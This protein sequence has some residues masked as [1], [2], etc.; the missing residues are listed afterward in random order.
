MVWAPP[1]EP[2]AIPVTAMRHP[3]ALSTAVAIPNLDH[4]AAPT[5]AP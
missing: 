4:G 5:W 3:A 1:T 2:G